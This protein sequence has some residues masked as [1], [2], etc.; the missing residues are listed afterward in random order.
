MTLRTALLGE[1]VDSRAVPSQDVLSLGYRA[2]V[3]R[4]GALRVVASEVIEH[5]S[6]WDVPYPPQIAPP[7]RVYV[8]PLGVELPV[9]PAR[10]V[11]GPLPT[12]SVRVYLDIAEEALL[13]RLSTHLRH[14]DR[15]I[16]KPHW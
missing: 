1:V 12:L 9:A 8:S 13:R 4:V 16:D 6:R 3:L 2:Y 10:Y 14:L 11:P 5:E 7:M 15:G